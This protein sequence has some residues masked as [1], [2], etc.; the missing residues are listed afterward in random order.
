MSIHISD[1]ERKVDR[2]K[3]SDWAEDEALKRS[4]FL[5]LHSD[6]RR[7]LNLLSTDKLVD[8]HTSPSGGLIAFARFE[9]R[10]IQLTAVHV[11]FAHELNSSSVSQASSGGGSFKASAVNSSSGIDA[12]KA[13]LAL[14][15]HSLGTQM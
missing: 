11:R 14:A 9:D 7:R 5:W 1:I 3:F 12:S 8:L 15:S 13:S 4:G 6:F 10:R 2:Q